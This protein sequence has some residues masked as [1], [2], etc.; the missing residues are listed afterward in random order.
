VVNVKSQADLFEVVTAL[1]ATCCF[2]SGLNRWQQKS[3]QDADDGDHNQQLD[4]RESAS[5]FGWAG[6]GGSGARVGWGSATR[7]GRQAG[8][9]LIFQRIL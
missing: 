1:H 6:G 7:L 5:R 4:Q 2:A 9:S 3:N 8:H